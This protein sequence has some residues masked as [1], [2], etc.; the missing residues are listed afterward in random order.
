MPR[1]KLEFEYVKK[2]FEDNGCILL[3]SSYEG[4]ATKLDYICNCG[5]KASMRWSS[6]YDG[7]RCWVCKTER[8]AAK[9]R[10]SWEKVKK[11]FDT[12]NFILLST[13]DEY[14]NAQ[15]KLKYIC[16]KGHL[17]NATYSNISRG[18]GCRECKIEGSRGKG[19]SQYR[20]D[21]SDEDRKNGKRNNINEG[22]W[23]NQVYKNNN[24]QCVICGTHENLRAHH[25]NSWNL[26]PNE[27][28]NVD[29]GITLCHAHHMD[30]H[31]EYGRGNN[32]RSQ[33]LEWYFKL[34]K[35]EMLVLLA[36]LQNR[37]LSLE[38][39]PHSL[40]LP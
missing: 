25:L 21:L 4:C 36:L 3:S 2:Y 20:H 26:F 18:W 34:L 17:S 35:A 37:K 31:R 23:R 12:K 39:A 8:A 7:E 15:S 33:F 11:A 10:N 5:Q 29:N 9:C 16:N 32:T 28:L 27:R 24:F 6:F 19:S 13:P 14:K 40:I 1:G 38:I 22:S 30:F